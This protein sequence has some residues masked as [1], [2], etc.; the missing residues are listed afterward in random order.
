MMAPMLK[1]AKDAVGDAATIIKIDVNKNPEVAGAYGIQGVPTWILF[2][3]GEIKWRQ[4]GVV[5]VQNWV[6]VIEA[7]CYRSL[8]RTKPPSLKLRRPGKGTKDTMG[9]KGISMVSHGVLRVLVVQI[10]QKDHLQG[11][12]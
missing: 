4:S 1:Q 12:I 5:P 10:I 11:R 8:F 7:I 6:A 9:H 3:D 2:K